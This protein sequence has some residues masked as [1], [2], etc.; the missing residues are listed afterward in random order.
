MSIEIVSINAR[1][2]PRAVR[3]WPVNENTVIADT[4]GLRRNERV[5]ARHADITQTHGQTSRG[6]YVYPMIHYEYWGR[7]LDTELMPGAFGE[8]LTVS[9]AEEFNVCVGDHWTWGSAV[10]IVSGPG[11]PSRALD[12]LYATDI[13][14]TMNELGLCG[15]YLKTVT[16]GIVPTS[17]RIR[18]FPSA[19]SNISVLESLRRRQQQQEVTLHTTQ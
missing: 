3:K 2:K 15:W 13:R 16:S 18:S 12:L 11:A 17:G 4:C 9:G 6:I 7:Q 10:F 1:K 19:T 8:Q 5:L 14:S